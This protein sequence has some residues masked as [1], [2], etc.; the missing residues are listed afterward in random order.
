MNT[1]Y[2]KKL[3]VLFL[4]TMQEYKN[5]YLTQTIEYYLNNLESKY[6]FDIFIFFDNYNTRRIR[7]F[8]RSLEQY[9]N[10]SNVNDVILI[11]N[12]INKE[13]NIYK[14]NKKGFFD[15]EKF[16]LG[17]TH[18]INFHFYAAMDKM[19]ETDYENFL[20]LES[21]TKP[22]NKKWFDT[23]LLA[24]ENND[25]CILGSKYKGVNREHVYRQYYGNHLNGVGIYMNNKETL[26]LLKKSKQYIVEE[27]WKDSK[28]NS[29]HSE[30]KHKEFMNYDVAIYLVAK[31][32]SLED[33]LVDT[34]YITNQSSPG[35]EKTS[36]EDTLKEFPETMLIHRKQ[37]YDK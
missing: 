27:L 32:N 18:G 7:R 23:L 6:K 31:E 24:I 16:P 3:C 9:K 10:R 35:N 5:G 28:N 21:D 33:K 22:L 11:N 14:R 37:L 34:Q 8:Y 36:I 1:M 17:R 4:T 26:N 29:K 2:T 13:Q 15:L 12:N 25:F 20:L 19:F 30:K